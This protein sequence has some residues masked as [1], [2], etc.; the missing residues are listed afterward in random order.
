MRRKYNN[1]N[2]IGL[3]E[4]TRLV[5]K[6]ACLLAATTILFSNSVLANHTVLV[7]GEQDYDGDGLLGVDEDADGDQVFGTIMGGVT[8]IGDNGRVMIVTSGRFMEQVNLAGTGVTV[9]E[10][11]PGVNAV[12]EAFQAGGN[13]ADNNTRQQQPGIIVHSDG[14]FPLEIRNIVS[15]NWTDGIQIRG[16][17]RV[18]LDN[19]RVDSNVNYGI[20][21]LG[22]SS[23]VITD[24]QVNSSGFRRSGS[25]G[26]T[27]GGDIPPNPGIGIAFEETS[28]GYISLTTVAHS[29]S[30][31]I[32]SNGNVRLLGNTVFDNKPNYNG[33][34]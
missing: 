4:G 20:H 5:S 29:F 7:E 11:A 3:T 16:S 25:L 31:G 1:A 18:T 24:S 28:S 30:T 12:V 22:G 32:M 33:F 34:W 26:L 8:G 13:A 23:V 21:V 14:S 27:P 17:A 19:V 9:L 6:V 15:R 2:L 10:A